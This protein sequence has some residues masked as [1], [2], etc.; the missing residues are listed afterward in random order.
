MGKYKIYRGK[1]PSGDWKIGCTIDYPRRCKK[2]HLTQYHIL[3][4]HD[5][6]FIASNREIELQMEYGYK[7]DSTKY[8]KIYDDKIKP[9][10]EE[11]KAKIR[12]ARKG[13]DMSVQIKAMTQHNTGRTYTK[14][15]REAISKATMGRKWSDETRKLWSEQRKGVKKS[16]EFC[17][18]V[19]EAVKGY[20][21]SDEH[22][23]NLSLS[24]YGKGVIK[25]H[26]VIWMRNQ[27]QRKTDTF[28]NKITQ[29][30]LAEVF[31][32]K[33][34]LISQI[35]NKKRWGHI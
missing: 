5:C 18:K 9:A 28:G 29:D 33:Q 4:E 2:Q 8:Y 34:G 19:S 22:R 21:K 16:K 15:H 32:V 30:R 35:L 24:N 25:E 23:K 14:E 3:E 11:T 17:M 20:V 10:S 6:K 13:Q 26:H 7:V 31:G 12:K 27:Y 1:K